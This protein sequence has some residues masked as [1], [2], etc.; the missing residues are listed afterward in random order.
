MTGEDA[1]LST[2]VIWWVGYLRANSYFVSPRDE[3]RTDGAALVLG[4]TQGHLRNMRSRLEGPPC[5]G[6]GGRAVY[7]ILDLLLYDRLHRAA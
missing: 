4:C 3:V 6:R 1:Q 5:E 7:R 2:D